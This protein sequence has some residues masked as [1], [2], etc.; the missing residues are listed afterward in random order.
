MSGTRTYTQIVIAVIVMVVLFGCKTRQIPQNHDYRDS[1]YIERYI[2]DTIQPDTS[3][4]VTLIECDSVTN[5][6]IVQVSDVYLDDIR[7]WIEQK[8]NQKFKFNILKPQSEIKVIERSNTSDKVEVVEIER[9]RGK[10]EWFLLISGV[11]V[12]MIVIMYLIFKIYK[13]IKKIKL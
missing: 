8:T 4:I 12:W 13:L 11:V 1:V 6:P 5:K 7:L 2:R 9:K 3:Y 10:F